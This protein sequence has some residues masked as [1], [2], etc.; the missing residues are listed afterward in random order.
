MRDIPVRMR[1]VRMRTGKSESHPGFLC[2]AETT[3]CLQQRYQRAVAAPSVNFKERHNPE[4]KIIA[5]IS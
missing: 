3:M 2:Q 5:E 4:N 1:Q